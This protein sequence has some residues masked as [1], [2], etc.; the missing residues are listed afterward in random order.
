MTA[1]DWPPSVEA[2]TPAQETPIRMSSGLRG[3]TSTLLNFPLGFQSSWNLA[4][5]MQY[6]LTGRISLRAGYEPRASAVPDDR[7]NP[8][9]P[10][11]E[12]R[13]YSL[14]LGYKWDKDTEIDL[15]IATLQSKDSIPANTSCMANCTGIDNIVYNP[16]AGLDIET[17]SSITLVGL[18]FR[19]SF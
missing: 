5:G 16:Y 15:G 1:H 10:I 2:Q 9:V 3:S 13:Y 14:G 4:Y 12:A 8:L 18:A 7:R 17:E 6:D 19:T 11:N